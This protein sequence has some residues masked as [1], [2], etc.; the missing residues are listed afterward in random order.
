M[1]VGVYAQ[2]NSAD[3][4]A[5]QPDRSRPDPDGDAPRPIPARI[6]R[7]FRHRDDITDCFVALASADFTGNGEIVKA[8]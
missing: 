6:R 4:G 5:G 8:Q 2:E 1:L 7:A 3:Q